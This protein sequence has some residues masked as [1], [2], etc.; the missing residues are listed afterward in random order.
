MTGGSFLFNPLPLGQWKPW[1]RLKF[2]QKFPNFLDSEREQVPWKKQHNSAV[3]PTPGKTPKD[4]D[5]TKCKGSL[6]WK[7]KERI[8][9]G[10]RTEKRSCFLCIKLLPN[11]QAFQAVWAV[12]DRR[13]L[14]LVVL[15][16]AEL[17]SHIYKTSKER[18]QKLLAALR[19]TSWGI[20]FQRDRASCIGK[21]GFKIPLGD[22]FSNLNNW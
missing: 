16:W 7:K 5:R 20:S 8:K 15:G 1:S 3:F 19:S 14:C 13:K 21:P 11:D 18:N 2:N 17:R 10:A 4:L 22:Y 6:T 9:Y 12:Q